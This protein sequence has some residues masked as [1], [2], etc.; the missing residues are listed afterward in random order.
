M[1][2]WKC[3]FDEVTLIGTGC[4]R[5][6][7]P[8][9]TA[10]DIDT[11]LCG[12]FNVNPEFY[13]LENDVPVLQVDIQQAITFSRQKGELQRDV[14]KRCE[15][16]I[17]ARYSVYEQLNVQHGHYGEEAKLTCSTFILDCREESNR[18]WDLI[19]ASTTKQEA[20]DAFATLTFPEA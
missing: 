11:T 20:D 15:A 6:P 4:N 12:W 19:E 17:L 14:N 5:E 2:T 7:G 13:K 16:H 18:V 3:I 10:R 9:E 8:G 1:Q